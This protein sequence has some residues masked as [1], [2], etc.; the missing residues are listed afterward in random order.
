MAVLTKTKEDYLLTIYG[1][2]AEGDPV[3]NA[4][5]ASRLGVAAPTVSAMLERLARDG[6]I[7]IDDGHQVFFTLGG[8]RTAEKLAR[9]HRLIEHWLIRTLGMGW[10]E[11]HEE[12]DR[13]EHSVSHELTDRISAA[14]GHPPTC[15]HGLPIPGNF[16]ETDVGALDRLAN[17]LPGSN[18]RVVRL[19]EPAEEDAALLH[20]FESK[21]L[22]PGRVLHVTE[23]TP[24]GH[25]VVSIEGETV[26]VEQRVAANLWTVQA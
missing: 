6:L 9:R 10:A 20:Y 25:L 13:L 3:I 12:A 18:V 16:P 8:E 23:I 2:R 24:S 5:L 19:S 26:V 15:P 1:M 11:V 21:R 4:R 7:W 14:L 17:A 22:V